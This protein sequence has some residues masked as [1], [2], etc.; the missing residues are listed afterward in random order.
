MAIEKEDK[1]YNI[2]AID[3]GGIKGIIP[4]KILENMENYAYQYATKKNYD[5]PKHIDITGN[6]I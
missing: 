1:P 4:A 6:I 2:L 5:I 3:G